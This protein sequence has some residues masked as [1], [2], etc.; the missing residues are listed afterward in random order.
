M[1]KTHARLA[2]LLSRLDPLPEL[3]GRRDVRVAEVADADD[4]A[5]N[6]FLERV[7]SPAHRRLMDRA[8]LDGEDGVPAEASFWRM[9]IAL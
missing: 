1:P 4:S 6:A 3:D 7:S 8:S 2:D 5:A 9:S